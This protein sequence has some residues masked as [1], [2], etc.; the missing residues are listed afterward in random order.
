MPLSF[1]AV[2][3]AGGSQ[4]WGQSTVALAEPQVGGG[5]GHIPS[6]VAGAVPGAISHVAAR[7]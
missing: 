6:T 3:P 5:D 2:P 4:G 7:G 1:G